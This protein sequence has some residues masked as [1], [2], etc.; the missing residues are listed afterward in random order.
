VTLQV[1]RIIRKP[2]L[3]TRWRGGAT[4]IVISLNVSP[5]DSFREGTTVCYMIHKHCCGQQH[6]LGGPSCGL[7]R[8]LLPAVLKII[9]HYCSSNSC[10]LAHNFICCRWEVPLCSSKT[11]RPRLFTPSES[12]L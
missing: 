2:L 8:E 7:W 6:P 4:L 9:V 3:A 1:N 10:S 12:Q 11:R 5:G